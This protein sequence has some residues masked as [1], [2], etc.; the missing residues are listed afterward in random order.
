MTK[1]KNMETLKS[2]GCKKILYM[3]DNES[4]RENIIEIGELLDYEIDAVADGYNAIKYYQEAFSAGNTYSA[5]IL[6]LT[7]QGSDMQGDD[8]LSELLKIDPNVK[9]IVFSGHSTKPIVANYKDYGFKGRL[10]KP[11]TIDNLANVLREV[12]G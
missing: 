1:E 12:C 8:V 7:I 9:A 11:V 10:D 6:D 2:G 3:D 4:L 5:V